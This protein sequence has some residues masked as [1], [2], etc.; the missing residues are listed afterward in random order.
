MQPPAADLPS[1]DRPAPEREYAAR[2]AARRAEEDRQ[3]RCYAL[4]GRGRRVLIGLLV[5][6][7]LLAEKESTVGKLVVIVPPAVGLE[8]VLLGRERRSRAWRRAAWSAQFYEDRLARVSDRWAGTGSSGL[9]FLDPD[10]PC[11]LDLDLFG[12]G[13]VFELLS[14]PAS[15]AGEAALAGRLLEP[16][17]TETVR[18]RQEAVAELRDRL[19]LREETALLAAEAPARLDL[20]ALA[21]W[22]RQ[23]P[24][25]GDRLARPLAW[26][27]AGLVFLG[28]MAVLLL[29][30]D[31]LLL[32]GVLLLA[33]GFAHWLHRRV[34]QVLD[35]IEGRAAD[36]A[37]LAQLFARLAREPF[38]SVRLRGLRE[39]LGEGGSSAFRRTARLAR[40]VGRV[41]TAPLRFPFLATT[42]LALAVAEW[43][44]V[45]G[46]DLARWCAAVAEFEADS[47]LAAYAYEHSADPFPE[48]VAKA[49]YFDGEGLGHPL[50]PEGRC[51]RNDVRLEGERRL[52]MVSGSNMSGKS[53][54]LRTVGVNA[55]LAVAGA[56]VRARR[57]R[58][59][60][61]VV[62]AT[63]RIQDSL[64]AGQS[65]FYAEIRRLRQ[66]LDLAQKTPL[67]LFLLDELL[68]GTNSH[69]REVGAEAVLRLLLDAGAVGLVT[70]HD[71]ALTEIADRLSPRAANIHFEDQVE[72]GQMTFDYRA[73]PGVVS[74]SNAL[75]LMRALG[76]EV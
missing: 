46:T 12:K 14:L 50:I 35:P 52:L 22:A 74:K 67:V 7:A 68:Q 51:V 53:T 63:L 65:R 44:R 37:L 13:S 43:R 60:P 2:L 10:H 55:V 45:S 11:A 24:L 31:P 32:L 71:L 3:A 69:D 25:P 64:Q 49:P 48:I 18:Q 17:P 38:T 21:D 26:L 36:L 27:L 23:P 34:R 72:D 47:A 66:I 16:A 28:L 8:F 62:G 57:L 19:D 4:L 42:R 73:R 76:I 15:R 39:A 58:I 41:R 9:R 56:P 59:S 29:G 5:L 20:Q 30:V 33:G 40:L 54:L 1:A 70:T 75:A 6:L 61:L